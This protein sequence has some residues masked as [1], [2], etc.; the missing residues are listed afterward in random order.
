LSETLR[1]INASIAN[2]MIM[3]RDI[4]GMERELFVEEQ[5]SKKLT[6]EYFRLIFWQEKKILQITEKK[7]QISILE[8]EVDVIPVDKAIDDNKS[9]VEKKTEFVKLQKSISRETENIFTEIQ[10][11][12]N[13]QLEISNPSLELREIIRENHKIEEYRAGREKDAKKSAKEYGHEYDC[14]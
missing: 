3:I 7:T 12:K 8:K 2:E 6:K 13:L 5:E 1:I 11:V 4:S 10:R 9:I 14:F